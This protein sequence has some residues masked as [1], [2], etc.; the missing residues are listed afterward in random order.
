MIDPKRSAAAKRGWETRRR[1]ISTKVEFPV[2]ENVD[3]SQACITDWFS[4]KSMNQI[5][6]T[7]LEFAFVNEAGKQCH[8]FAFC[9]DYLQDAVWAQINKSKAAIYGFSYEHGVN[10]PLDFNSMR[11][12]VRN[13]GDKDFKAKC[14]KALAFIQQID[15]AQGFEPTEM[16]FGGKYKDKTD[17][18]FVYVSD[19]RWLHSPVFVSFYSL[20]LRVGMTYDGG[21]WKSHFGG[22]KSYIG[23]NDKSYT[24]S[25]KKVLDKVIGKELEELFAAKIDDNYPS[26]CGVSGL[27]NYSGIVSY[28]NNNVPE[29]VKSKWNK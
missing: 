18:V 24:G 2:Q 1:N 3:V 15:A 11:M 25:A 28:A 22:A 16:I 13:K 23:R 17:D 10:P 4:D 8:A 7:G 6:S 5:Y 9:K 20:C 14:E 27:H 29:K 26:D 12:A 21:D 19:K